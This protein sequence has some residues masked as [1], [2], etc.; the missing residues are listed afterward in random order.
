MLFGIASGQRARRANDHLCL[1]A[2]ISKLQINELKNRGVTTTTA[3]A[4]VPLPL[5]WKPERGSAQTCERIREQA[6]L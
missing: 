1:V 3:L 4:S 2:G 5:Q 6:R